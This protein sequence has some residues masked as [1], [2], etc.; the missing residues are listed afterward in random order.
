[1]NLTATRV[2]S[3]ICTPS[4]T[5]PMPPRPINRVSRNF[6]ATNSFA[7]GSRKSTLFTVHP[8]LAHE[9]L[10]PPLLLPAMSR[11]WVRQRIEC[12]GVSFQAVILLRACAHSRTDTQQE[13]RRYWSEC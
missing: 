9:G 13:L 8:S 1:M 12:F 6:S 7:A 3:V 11:P 2:P 5:D 4:H 10:W